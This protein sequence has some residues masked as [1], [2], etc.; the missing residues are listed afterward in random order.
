MNRREWLRLAAAVPLAA[1]NIRADPGSKRPTPEQLAWQDM[2]LSMFVHFGP[3]TWQN[4]E[5]DDLSTPLGQINP[6][7]LDTEQW[8]DTAVA[9]GARQIVFVAKHTGGFCWW[10]TET[11]QYS[12]ANTPW[13][14]GKGDVMRDL[15]V[16][17]QKRNLRLG[18]Y[19]SPQDRS[20]KVGL[21]GK[22]DNPAQQATYS[23][24][25]RQ[26]LTELLSRYGEISEIWF[27]GS[28]VVDTG[29]LL[30]R[31][32]PHAIIF[33]S[34]YATIRWVGNEDGIAP[35]P[36]WNLVSAS[37]ARS[38]VATAKDG[39]PGG[40]TWLPC[41]VDARI[42]NTWFWNTE[43]DAHLKSLDRLMTMY[44]RSVGHGALLL[45]NNTPDTTGLIPALHAKRT[46]E[47]GAEIRRRFDKP[48]A[49][50][51]GSN[52][53]MELKLPHPT[54]IDHVVLME[55]LRKGQHV[56]AYSVFGRNGNDWHQLSEGTSIGHK[57][58]D[59]FRAVTVSSLIVRFPKQDGDTVLSRFAAYAVGSGSGAIG[60]TPETLTYS[61]IY[62]WQPSSFDSG[63]TTWDIS[64]NQA[65]HDAGEYL[66][67]FV[68]TG[69]GVIVKSVT[70]IAEGTAHDEYVTRVSDRM[71]R[72]NIPGLGTTLDLRAVITPEPGDPAFGQ[73]VLSRAK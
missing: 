25:Y 66:V 44:Y 21:G 10:Q 63:H 22:A 67:E 29:D 41:E 30:Q 56:Q 45:L 27:D 18:V 40:N 62:N 65:V 57:K 2:E 36:N 48:I 3:A 15:A 31:Y 73:I 1:G 12:V 47:F 54:A 8:A 9:L 33:Q 17:C 37:A 24:L 59:P 72:L 52:G 58:I 11:S 4:R 5:Y 20:L 53:T 70:L 49:Q 69:G 55:D 51:H 71:Y 38:G 46:E 43:S 16:S 26:Q 6:S 68:V 42:H 32:A 64:L 50:T 7:K 23:K 35:D 60:P 13:R 14:A 39:N 34:P 61:V 28:N 19:L